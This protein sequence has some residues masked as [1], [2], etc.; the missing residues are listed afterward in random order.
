[1]KKV[2]SEETIMCKAEVGCS[3]DELKEEM[4]KQ[5]KMRGEKVYGIFNGELYVAY[6]WANNI[7]D[8]DTY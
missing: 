4:L 3:L 7:G 2:M 8:I 5:V 6:R 1:M